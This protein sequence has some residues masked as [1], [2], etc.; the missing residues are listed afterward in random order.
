MPEQVALVDLGSNAVR[1]LLAELGSGGQVRI[2]CKARAQTRLGGG[3]S[4]RLPR[5]AIADTLDA[6]RRFLRRT[7]NGQSP[8]VLAIATSAVRD[9]ANR[10]RLLEP[11]RRRHGV[12]VAVLS[13][14]EEARLGALA[15]LASLHFRAGTVMDLGG[16]SLQ[17][18]GVREGVPHAAVSL[19]VGAVRATRRFLRHDPPRPGELSALRDEIR[20]RLAEAESPV[21]AGG[22]LIGLGGTVRALASIHLGGRHRRRRHGLR[23]SRHDVTR[24]RTRL[25]ALPLRKRRRVPGL[26]AER[27]DIIVAGA[28]I[29]EELM[30]AGDYRAVTACMRGVRDGLLLVAAGKGSVS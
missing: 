7:R 20:Q 17:L 9:A 16:G 29:V 11:L 19:P 18:T 1:L 27:A 26:D 10:D 12:E 3:R 14:R 6:V 30:L 13:G 28:V 21:P 8:R 22:T 23:L 24:I 15:A 5:Q 2:L 25:E 4:G